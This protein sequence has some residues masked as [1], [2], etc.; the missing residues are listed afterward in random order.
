MSVNFDDLL[1]KKIEVITCDGR[2]LVGK[3]FAIDQVTNLALTDAEERIFAKDEGVQRIALGMYIVRGD[4]VAI[5]GEMDDE[6]DDKL[7][8]S[9]IRGDAIPAITH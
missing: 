1:N 7:D 9:Q 5:V 8:F 2:V 6:V 3:L 4:H